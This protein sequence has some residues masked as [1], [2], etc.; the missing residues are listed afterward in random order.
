MNTRYTGLINRYRKWL[1]VTDAMQ[2]VT[3]GEGNTPLIRLQNIQD[4]T[5]RSV[6]LYV[7]F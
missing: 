2:V 1:P 4:I 7:K 6:A 3:L 5:R